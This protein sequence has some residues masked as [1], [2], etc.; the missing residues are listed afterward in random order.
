MNCQDFKKLLATMTA[1]DLSTEMREHSV[2]CAECRDLLQAES[3]VDA[4][5]KILVRATP[6]IDLS[7]RIM[8][9]VRTLAAARPAEPTLLER[10][11]EFLAGEFLKPAM[12]LGLAALLAIGLSISGRHGRDIVSPMK[13]WQ[14]ASGQAVAEGAWVTATSGEPL[15]LAAAG[16]ATA[17]LTTGRAQVQSQGLFLADGQVDVSV[18]KQPIGATFE[19]RTDLG[20]VRVIGTRFVVAL[21]PKT[22]DVQVAEGVVTVTAGNETVTLTAGQRH[23]VTATEKPASAGATTATPT[24]A[25]SMSHGTANASNDAETPGN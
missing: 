17:I 6:T 18:P 1:A 15:R 4:G 12:A 23:T 13:G 7:G 21:T 10:L 9:Q 3:D 2:S 5:L 19:V 14:T 11:R 8:N 22:L 20:T 24:A 25:A 16:G